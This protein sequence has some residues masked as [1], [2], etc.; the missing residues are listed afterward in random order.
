[1]SPSGIDGQ[2]EDNIMGEP[3]NDEC[4]NKLL[5]KLGEVEALV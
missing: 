3:E 2:S 4:G 5:M 1:M